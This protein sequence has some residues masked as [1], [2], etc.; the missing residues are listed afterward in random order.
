MIW[1]LAAVL[2]FFLVRYL[3]RRRTRHNAREDLTTA[4]QPVTTWRGPKR[5]RGGVSV[6]LPRNVT[7]R[8]PTAALDAL[9]RIASPRTQVRGPQRSED[10]STGTDEAP[11]HGTTAREVT[12]GEAQE[13]TTH[14][15]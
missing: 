5:M 9:E 6:A 1:V 4:F 3:I 7:V 11:E 8:P 10:R 15:G 14:Q 2:A 12:N 13:G